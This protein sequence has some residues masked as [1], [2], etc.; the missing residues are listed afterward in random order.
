RLSVCDVDAGA[1][2][3]FRVVCGA[4]NVHTGMTAAFARVGARL[5]GG[6]HGQGSGTLEEAQPLQAAIIR[7]V[8]SDGMLCSELELGLS[9]DHQGIVELDSDVKP[10]ELLHTYLQIPDIVLDIAITPNRGDCLSILG[11]A[12]EI[13]ALFGA[14]LQSPNFTAIKPPSGNGAAELAIDVEIRAPEL[15]PR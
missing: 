3:R 13:S 15:C 10:G 8:P 11:L 2:G 6:V 14:K 1:L 7:G 9:A 4:P 5:A 12:R